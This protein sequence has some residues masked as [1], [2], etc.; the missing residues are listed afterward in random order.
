MQKKKEF[1]IDY[2]SICPK[3]TLKQVLKKIS[4]LDQLKNSRVN[5]AKNE[6]NSK[7]LDET[8]LNDNKGFI[9]NLEV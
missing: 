2:Y 1:P 4:N 6:S 5:N 9:S 3:G 8:E 7:I